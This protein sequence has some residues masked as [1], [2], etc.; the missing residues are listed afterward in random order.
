[1]EFEA[2]LVVVTL[3]VAAF[4]VSVAVGK[5]NA[6]RSRGMMCWTCGATHPPFAQFCRRCGKR[7]Q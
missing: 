4:V 1:M 7:L 2:F 6:A 3:V 5:R